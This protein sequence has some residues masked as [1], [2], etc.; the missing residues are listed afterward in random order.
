MICMRK[1]RGSGAPALILETIANTAMI[2][3]SKH[4]YDL[5][6]YIFFEKNFKLLHIQTGSHIFVFVYFFNVLFLFLCKNSTSHVPPFPF[7]RRSWFAQNL[8]YT[9]MYMNFTKLSA[10]QTTFWFTKIF[11]DFSPCKNSTY[12]CGPTLSPEII[13]L[14]YWS[15]LMIMYCLIINSFLID[16]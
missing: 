7:P 13:V 12:N 9:T 15:N 8:I 3:N 5:V 14:I 2:S 1:K 10:F 16:I 11:I 4:R 6:Q